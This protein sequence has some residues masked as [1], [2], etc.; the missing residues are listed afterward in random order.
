MSNKTDKKTCFV[1]GPI[2][3][4]GSEARSI[5][6]WLLKGIVKPVL[7]A[8]PFLYEVTRADGIPDPGLITNQIIN[9]ILDADLVVADLTGQ[10]PNAFYELALRHMA[11]KPV[12]HMIMN[13]QPIP[14]DNKDYRTIRYGINEIE[15]F[16]KAK[17]D[18]AE[19]ARAVLKEGYKVSNPVTKARGHKELTASGDT[20]DQL[21]SALLN[22]IEYI[23]Y[24]LETIEKNPAL[25]TSNEQLLQA[26]PSGSLA[27][28]LIEERPLSPLM[29]VL[30]SRSANLSMDD[31]SDKRTDTKT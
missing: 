19:Q 22:S 8:E 11:A 12:I 15:I 3:E 29:Q 10:N 30:L 26:F 4:E 25:L 18:L 20:R 14:F 5:A 7:E 1:I 27:R 28:S 17:E 2:G 9:A 6:N 23:K 13:G 16:E 31:I 24:R 21:I